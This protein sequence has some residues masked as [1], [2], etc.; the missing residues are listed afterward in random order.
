MKGGH[1]KRVEKVREFTSHNKMFS[2]IAV[3]VIVFLLFSTVNRHTEQQETVQ[4][5]K[6]VTEETEAEETGWRFYPIDLVV[7]GVGDGFC[8][9][10][11]I[12]E[13]RKAKEG[14]N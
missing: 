5:R 12:R 11:I 6:T 10:M 13:R 3:L 4:D 2:V 8:S 14:L 7:L 1:K 9:I